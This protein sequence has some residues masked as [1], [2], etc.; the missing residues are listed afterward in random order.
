M[1]KSNKRGKIPQ[2]DWPSIMA[3]Y[4]AG[5]TLSSI[6]RTYDC[7]PPAISYVVNR[8]RARQPKA[9]PPPATSGAESQLIKTA[10]ASGGANPPPEAAAPAAPAMPPP[11]AGGPAPR[12]ER[13]AWP[14]EPAG[15]GAERGHEMRPHAANGFA[16]NP[17]GGRLGGVAT[18]TP[19]AP[20][21]PRQPAAQSAAAT[22]NGD[23]RRRLHLSLGT[24]PPHTPAVPSA[25]PQPAERTT[26][27]NGQE[28][29]P[30]AAT[31]LGGLPAS[32]AHDGREAHDGRTAAEAEG[33]GGGP[34]GH[35]GA[36]R[37]GNGAERRTGGGSFIDKELRARV[38]S[39]IAAFLAAFDA[40][41]EE[42]S[43]VNRSLLREATDRLLRAGARTRIELERLEA[44]VPLAPRDGGR[45]N[46]PAWRDR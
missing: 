43:E 12:D 26:I 4:E 28:A 21:T 20:P 5:E 9:A 34:I 30:P 2:S 8:S 24:A 35:Y 42:D 41:L 29:R 6:A 32:Q 14:E 22:G 33:H 31:E 17:A 45:R 46:Q 10:A 37:P 16:G 40:A 27:G 44:R 36:V 19:A 1:E 3:R 23:A 13:K 18:T 39:D 38:D 7:S 15:D 11:I 25:L